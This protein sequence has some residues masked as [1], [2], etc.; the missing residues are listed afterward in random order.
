MI[1]LLAH[2]ALIVQQRLTEG[3]Y[4]CLVFAAAGLQ[5][6]Q[7]LQIPDTY[8]A[9]AAQHTVNRLMWQIILR[10]QLLRNVFAEAAL[11]FRQLI[12]RQRQARS[13]M[14]TAVLRQQIT[15]GIYRLVKIERRN[16]A[17]AALGN[18][19]VQAYQNRRQV[20]FVYQA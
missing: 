15:F 4:R 17:T 19:V 5:Q 8:F 20:V 2:S 6:C 13:L 14:V 10:T 11:E 7:L 18:A 16:T 3:K 1:A 12:R 9:A